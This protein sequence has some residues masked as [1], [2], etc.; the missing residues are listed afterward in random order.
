MDKQFEMDFV[1]YRIDSWVEN[2]G[3]L[4]RITNAFS[5]VKASLKNNVMPVATATAVATF[6]L[7]SFSSAL[8][9]PVWQKAAQTAQS[10]S[11]ALMAKLRATWNSNIL[12]LEHP[13]AEG[14]DSEVLAFSTQALQ[15]VA[16]RGGA[17]PTALAGKSE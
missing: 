16:A 12:A 11:S 8:A 14:V 9:A 1:G 3:I 17:L 7:F 10:P 5:S 13:S 6:S 4:T 15:A 2:G